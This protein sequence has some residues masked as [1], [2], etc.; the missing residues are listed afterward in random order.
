[1]AVQQ[2][3]I[4][5]LVLTITDGSLSTLGIVVSLQGLPMIGFLVFGGMVTDR[6]DRRKV[7]AGSQVSLAFVLALVA[8]LALNGNIQIWHIAIA[9][10]LIGIAQG[11]GIPARLA[12]TRDLVDRS[13]LMN[14]MALQFMLLNIAFIVGPPLAGIL[15]QSV[16]FSATLY[17]NACLYIAGALSL[18]FITGRQSYTKTAAVNLLGQ[19]KEALQFVKT[20]P[21]IFTIIVLGIVIAMFGEPYIT[22]MPGFAR[23]V[24]GLDADQAGFLQSASGFGALT[25][26]LL[27]A[28]LGNFQHKNWLW[29]GTIF[30]F[31]I[32]L[33]LFSISPWFGLSVVLLFL[34]GMGDLNF[35]SLGTTLIQLQSP[36]GIM[37]RVM[38]LWSIGASFMFIGVLP[39]AFIGDLLGLRYALAGGAII[40]FACCVWLGLI[41]SSIRNMQSY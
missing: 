37:G 15:I 5:W 23:E 3:S 20:S 18:L 34:T 7:L 31:A 16:G 24:M 14:A 33:F 25:G 6:L 40:C 32:S 8:T 12:L 2:F 21:A 4:A 13:E 35:V 28:S 19:L 41:R 1:M 22:L 39:M 38:G 36:Q 17:V 29:L 26:S 10:I 30:V 27:L 11:F 9:A